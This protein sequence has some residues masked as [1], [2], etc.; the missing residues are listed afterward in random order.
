MFRHFIV[1]LLLLVSSGFASAEGLEQISVFPEQ[2]AV[3]SPIF[4]Q[5]DISLP[6]PCYILIKYSVR[7]RRKKRLIFTKLYYKRAELASS[8]CVRDFHHKVSLPP[9]TRGKW[10]A[11][12]RIHQGKRQVFSGE[13]LAF[14]VSARAGC[15][16]DFEAGMVRVIIGFTH[17]PGPDEQALVESMGGTIKFTYTGFPYAFAPAIAATIPEEAIEELEINPS[18]TR[19]EKIGCGHIH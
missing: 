10:T 6:D 2:P 8:D 4:I 16:F 7:L 5:L 17:P 15:N 19:V 18:V 14:T 1:A 11:K 13:E 3:D 12:V 9:L